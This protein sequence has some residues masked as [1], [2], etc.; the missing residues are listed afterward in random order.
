MPVSSNTYKEVGVIRQYSLLLNKSWDTVINVK[1][2]IVANQAVY[3]LQDSQVRSTG[4]EG[5][6]QFCATATVCGVAKN[7]T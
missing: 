2:Q 5:I 7:W 4:V 1:E 3:F 6:G